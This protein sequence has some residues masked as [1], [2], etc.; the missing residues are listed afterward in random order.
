[1]EI[2]VKKRIGDNLI[3]FK[4]DERE[5][6]IAISKALA[7]AEKDEC[8]LCHNTDVAMYS[9]KTISKKDG[10]T[11]LFIRRKCKKCSATSSLSEY[12]GNLGYYWTQWEIW[13]PQDNS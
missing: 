11:F 1:M 4:I 5:D 3:E 6:K 2:I 7:F 13:K 12:Q 10:K 9:Q 8:S